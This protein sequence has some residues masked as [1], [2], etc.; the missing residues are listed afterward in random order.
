MIGIDIEPFAS[1]DK[2]VRSRLS[3]HARPRLLVSKLEGHP[4]LDLVW[5]ELHYSAAHAERIHALLDLCDGS[6]DLKTLEEWLDWPHWHFASLLATLYARGALEDASC[7]EAPAQLCQ[8]HLVARGRTLRALMGRETDLLGAK[9]HRRLLLGSLVETWHYVRAAA[10]HIGAALGHAPEGR[11]RDG[12]A[13]MLIDECKHGKDLAGGLRQAGLSDADLAA[14]QPLP[15]TRAVIQA[16]RTLGATDLLSYGVCCAINESPKSDTAIKE[17]WG[18]IGQLRLLP[19]AAIA[20]FRGHELEDEASDHT[21]IA[22]LLFSEHETLSRLQQLR[23][24]RHVQAFIAVQRHCYQA[25]RNA[26]RDEDGAAYF[27]GAAW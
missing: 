9:P 7:Q 20:P 12:L 4:G 2:S 26:Y 10:E 17:T 6:R 23:I 5:S 8:E 21:A 24:R 22:A 25:I 19:E 15:E 1:D 11:L 3:P 27:K 13:Q 16:L 14:S 18:Q